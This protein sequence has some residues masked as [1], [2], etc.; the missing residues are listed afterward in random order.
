LLGNLGLGHS[1][2][3][4]DQAKLSVLVASVVSSTLALLVLRVFSPKVARDEHDDLPVL[5]D[6]PRFARGYGVRHCPVGPVLLGQTLAEL[7]V[8]RRFGVTVIGIWRGGV[9]AGARHLEPTGAEYRMRDEDVLLVAGA[10]EAL[11]RF[12]DFAQSGLA[13]E[14]AP[15][16]SGAADSERWS[17][18]A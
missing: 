12:V 7:D 10:D 8:R 11:E 18:L 2:E 3:L 9:S 14:P 4:E 17:G 15:P 13:G 6:V 16:G 1:R 5:L